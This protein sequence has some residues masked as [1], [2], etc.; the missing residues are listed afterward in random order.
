MTKK[1][2]VGIA[3]LALVVAGV[4]LF[5]KSNTSLVEFAGQFEERNHKTFLQGFQV[6]SAGTSIPR[7]N[8]GICYLQPYAATIT[9]TSTVSVE[10]QGTAV[11]NTPALT[12]TSALRGVSSGD[13]VSVMLSTAT[14]GT[15]VNGLHIAGA[16]AS[17]TR[18]GY[19]TLR[20]T[21]LTGGTFTWPIGTAAT[22]TA[23]Y[24]SVQ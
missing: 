5:S 24:I 23:S 8:V 21:N 22:G 6:G 2:V 9:A 20:V 7:V 18:A 3:T 16:T 11:I 15:V 12:N 1:I 10:C 17:T 13:K 4:A 14:V 19:I